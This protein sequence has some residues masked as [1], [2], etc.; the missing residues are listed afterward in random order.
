MEISF[1]SSSP[2][3]EKNRH[4]PV[5]MFFLIIDSQSSTQTKLNIF[6]S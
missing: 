4:A 1:L 3:E 6:F 2:K 5:G